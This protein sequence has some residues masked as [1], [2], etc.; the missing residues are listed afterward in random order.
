MTGYPTPTFDDLTLTAP[1][2]PANG[3]TGQT[4][5]EALASSISAAF[6]TS[7]IASLR[8]LTSATETTTCNVANYATPGDQGGGTFVVD[9]SDTTTADNGGTIIVDA[10]GRRWYRQYV[11]AIKPEWFGAKND[12]TTD[13]TIAISELAAISLPV[14]TSTGVYSTTLGTSA[15]PKNIAGRGQIKDTSGNR[16]YNFIRQDAAPTFLGIPTDASTAF[17]GDI[18]NL[19]FGIE[20]R[21]TAA[22]AFGTPTTGYVQSPENAAVFAFVDNAAGYNNDT[23]DNGGRTGG[24][25]LDLRYVHTGQGDFG[26]IF[27][28][29]VATGAKT[30]AANFLANPAAVA[31][32]GQLFAG[33]N[34]VYLNITELDATDNGY[35]AA[36]IGAVFNFNRSIGTAALGEVWFGVRPQSVGT[37]PADVVYSASGNWKRVL[38]TTDVTLDGNQA[39]ITLKQGHRIFFES[40]E[41]GVVGWGQTV[42]SS[43]IWSDGANISTVYGNTTAL[44]VNASTVTVGS[45]GGLIIGSTG[46]LQFAGGNQFGA[47]A[48]AATFLAS[49]KPGSTASGPTQWIKVT[50]N[51]FV[52]WVPAW[53]N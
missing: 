30:G 35:D 46:T 51:G 24:S 2:S 29:G 15:L 36:A 50:L 17:N 27:L 7:T 45:S 53:P 23:A 11:D 20:K 47:G 13:A 31:L 41:S 22:N 25:I 18:S 14:E 52:F 44:Q 9:A 48:T 21:I 16:A 4:S 43:Y 10:A 32:N 12:G 42:G 28:S 33:N 5:V 19:V 6:Y 1:L 34:G 40:V 8:A 3:G 38:D 49:N 37:Q 26:C 39:A